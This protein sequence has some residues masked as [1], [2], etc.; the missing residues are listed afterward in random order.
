MGVDY[1]DS[2]GMIG[3]KPYF[4]EIACTPKWVSM[5]QKASRF[6]NKLSISEKVVVFKLGV[7]K[8]PLLIN[9]VGKK[10]SA[11]IGVFNSE[12]NG[13]SYLFSFCLCVFKASA[14]SADL[15]APFKRAVNCTVTVEKMICYKYSI[16]SQRLVAFCLL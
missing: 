1:F 15:I 12:K 16:V 11:A 5:N 2:V 6:M 7:R 10:I 8:K 9:S 13:K 4:T 3:N 14:I